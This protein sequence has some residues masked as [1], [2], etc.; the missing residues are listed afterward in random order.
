MAGCVDECDF[1]A[2]FCF[3]GKRSDCLGDES[4][5]LLGKTSFIRHMGPECIK[6]GCLSMVYVPHDGDNRS[7]L[8]IIFLIRF[9]QLNELYFLFVF[10]THQLNRLLCEDLKLVSDNVV[11][12]LLDNFEDVHWVFV[13]Q[14]PKFPSI[15]VWW[16]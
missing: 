13:K 16:N 8:P 15:D 4:K 2:F 7:P 6:Q 12:V 5:L 11:G 9:V 3:D 1:L 14:F 10:N